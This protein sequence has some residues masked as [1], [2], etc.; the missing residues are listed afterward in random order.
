[1]SSPATS[2]RG[3]LAPSWHHAVPL[4]LTMNMQPSQGAEGE[5]EF[6]DEP[7]EEDELASEADAEDVRC[8]KSLTAFH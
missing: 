5:S 3:R 7:M 6:E 4:L 2:F 8:F 1:M